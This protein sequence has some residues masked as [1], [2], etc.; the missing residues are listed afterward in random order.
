M[1]PSTCPF[2]STI[3]SPNDSA[4]IGPLVAAIQTLAGEQIADRVVYL[5]RAEPG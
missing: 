5:N 1:C 4:G 2:A 3:A